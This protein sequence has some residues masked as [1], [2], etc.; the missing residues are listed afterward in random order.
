M[1]SNYK[2]NSFIFIFEFLFNKECSSCKKK[3]A[4]LTCNKLGCNRNYH[5]PCAI[6]NSNKILN[7]NSNS[8]YF[9]LLNCLDCNL[10]NENLTVQCKIHSTHQ[11][12]R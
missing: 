12:K 9:N 4:T 11:I 2:I 8:S 3:G 5:Y 1:I 6:L 7:I 10:N